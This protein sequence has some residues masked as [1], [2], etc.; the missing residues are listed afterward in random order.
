MFSTENSDA[1]KLR[2]LY[3][4]CMGRYFRF[5][6]GVFVDQEMLAHKNPSAELNRK[7][8]VLTSLKCVSVYQYSRVNPSSANVYLPV[9]S[10]PKKLLLCAFCLLYPSAC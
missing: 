3:S 7:I 9:Q 1:F 6:T 8:C 2:V 4:V 10:R 5:E